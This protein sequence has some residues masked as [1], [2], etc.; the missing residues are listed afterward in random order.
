[1][2]IEKACK[3]VSEFQD[4]VYGKNMR[5]HNFCGQDRRAARCATC[6][7]KISLTGD[8]IKKSKQ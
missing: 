5:V 3:C 7:N 6:G 2:T 1:M 8:P 4:R